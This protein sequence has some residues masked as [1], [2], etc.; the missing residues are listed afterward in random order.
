MFADRFDALMKIAQV[1]NSRLGRAISMNS[2][3]IG[4]LRS[5]ARPLARK[6]DYIPP[7][8][9]YLAGHMTQ[10]YQLEAL[11]NLTGM[12]AVALGSVQDMA[13]F[14][15]QWLLAEQ[16]PSPA[17][18]QPN[19]DIPCTAPTQRSSECALSFYGNEGKRRA[20]ERFFSL[21]LAQE[22][23]TTLLLYSDEDMAWLYEDEAFAV[24]WAQ[25]FLRVVQKGSRVR[26]IHTVSRDMNEMMEAVHKW[27]PIYL[28]G[29]V[30]PYC[31][32]RLRDGVLARTLFI[33][34]HTAAVVSASVGR[35]TEGMLNHFITQRDAVDALTLE[36]ER[37]FALCR[38]LIRVFGAH[39]QKD[40]YR[41]AQR[42]FAAQENAC[43][44]AATPPL[45][46]MPKQMARDLSQHAGND[47][48]FAAWEKEVSAFCEQIETKRLYVAV[49]TPQKVLS[50][51]PPYPLPAGMF[52]EKIAYE[53]Q[54]Y[55]AHIARLEEL[56]AQHEKLTLVFRD[57]IPLDLFVYAKEHVGVLLAKT[58][59]QMTAF[60][61]G[62][63]N[64]TAA[65]WDYLLRKM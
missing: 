46:A 31:Y 64:M 38:P 12:P 5:G 18:D 58:D 8:C 9:A 55:L 61:V 11:Q 52:Y 44:C 26:I 51:K 19:A 4:R 47:A 56:A 2:S 63:Q 28:T 35:Q 50:E 48:F 37:Y 45:F 36:Y 40:F 43:Y 17:H 6:H 53:K 3:H 14:M 13:R 24:R 34:P 54:Q 1:S 62:E 33:A 65:V 21:V 32:P 29:S 15:E 57:D 7:M 42:L 60:A 41:E 49:P 25:L 59:A 30:E 39:A 10:A 16:T 23:P 27:L 22:K 20:V